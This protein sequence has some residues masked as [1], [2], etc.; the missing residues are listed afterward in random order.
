[1]ATCRTV[2]TPGYLLSGE[3]GEGMPLDKYLEEV[4]KE[5][6]GVA[7]EHAYRPAL[8]GSGLSQPIVYVAYVEYLDGFEIVPYFRGGWGQFPTTRTSA[9]G[10]DRSAG[11]LQGHG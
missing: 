10:E 3:T 4:Q 8:K 2:D 6:T 7:R 9:D 1:M 11:E 5:N